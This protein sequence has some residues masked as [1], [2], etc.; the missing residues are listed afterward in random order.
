MPPPIHLPVVV[1]GLL[2]VL[3]RRNHRLRA[4]PVKFT[5]RPVGVERPVPDHRPEGK[6]LQKLRHNGKVVRLA[7]QDHEAHRLAGCVRDCDDLAGQ[8]AP[9]SADSLTPGSPW[10]AGGLPVR[11]DDGA[12]D[13]HIPRSNLSDKALKTP[14]KIPD[15]AQRR[16]LLYTLFHLPNL[17][18]RSRQG[19]PTRFRQS[20]TAGKSLLSFAVPPGSVFLS[21]R[22]FSIRFH[23]KSVSTVLSRFIA[24][25]SFCSGAVLALFERTRQPNRRVCNPQC[26]QARV[27]KIVY[28]QCLKHLSGT[29]SRI[30]GECFVD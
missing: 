26:Q 1:P 10:R 17:S 12:V 24:C 14:S 20:T 4:T 29:T 21:G 28:F 2:P 22:M 27:E 7:G 16:N 19:A 13:G 23:M 6:A 9:G 11:L 15:S 25:I 8:T 30:F 3:P 18:G 5:D